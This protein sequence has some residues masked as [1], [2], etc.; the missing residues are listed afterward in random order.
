MVLRSPFKGSF[1]GTVE[2]TAKLS[3]SAL[4]FA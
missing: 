2:V 1:V 4:W 3:S